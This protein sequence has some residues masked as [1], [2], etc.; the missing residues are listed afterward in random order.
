MTMCNCVVLLLTGKL[1]AVQE[2]IKNQ[3]KRL[4]NACVP[5]STSHVTLVVMHLGSQEDVDKLETCLCL[6][7]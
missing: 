7:F 1:M 2:H 4:A 5:I 6:F 3:D